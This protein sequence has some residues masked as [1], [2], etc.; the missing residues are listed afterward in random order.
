[1]FDNGAAV[2]CVQVVADSWVVHVFVVQGADRTLNKYVLP[3][4]SCSQFRSILLWLLLVS[5]LP[6]LETSMCR[7][8]GVSLMA[9]GLTLNF[10]L[11]LG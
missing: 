11:L 2:R 7:L 3:D 10:L 5:P 9:S 8:P 1:M 6:P 4:D